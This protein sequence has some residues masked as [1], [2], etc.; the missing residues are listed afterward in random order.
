MELK[1]IDVLLNVKT[2][3]RFDVG[4]IVKIKTSYSFSQDLIG[5]IACVD[6]LMLCLDSSLPYQ[7]KIEE[8]DYGNIYSI[9]KVDKI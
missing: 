2:G 5:R 6:T 9:E 8:V 7:S 4:D 3:E 1:R